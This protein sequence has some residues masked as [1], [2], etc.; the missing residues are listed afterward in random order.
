M[1]GWI[2]NRHDRVRSVLLSAAVCVA[3][4]MA[5]AARAQTAGTYLI[6]FDGVVTPQNPTMTVGIWATWD[7]PANAFV[8]GGANFDVTAGD[9][10]FSNLANPF[11]HTGMI[12]VAVGNKIING[13]N[14]QLHIPS[15]GFFGSRDNPILILTAQWTTT[16]FTPRSVVFETSNTNSFFVADWLTGATTQLYPQSFSPGA[17]ASTVVPS[18]WALP[19]FMLGTVVATRRRRD[20]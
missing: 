19:V 16:D 8:F 7:D 9:G 2:E 13:Q 14:G 10:L 4:G 1:S 11:Q 15:L 20:G 12:G 5:G 17:G 18:P 3:M 6:T